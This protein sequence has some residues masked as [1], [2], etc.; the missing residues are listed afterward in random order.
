LFIGHSQCSG[1]ATRLRGSPVD[2]LIERSRGIDIRV[3]PQL[4]MADEKRGRGRLKMVK[5]KVVFR[6]IRHKLSDERRSIAS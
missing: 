5:E 1:I 2:R 6:P 4:N 3:F